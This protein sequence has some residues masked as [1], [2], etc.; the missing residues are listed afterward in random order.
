MTSIVTP[1]LI[2][3]MLVAFL[4]ISFL[5]LTSTEE[6]EAYMSHYCNCKWVTQSWPPFIV[7]VCDTYYHWHWSYCGFECPSS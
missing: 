2:A 3:L 4:G 6:A 7:Y 1:T 5:A